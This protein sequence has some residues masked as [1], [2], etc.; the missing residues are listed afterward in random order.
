MCTVH[1]KLTQ[2]VVPPRDFAFGFNSR[3]VN[4]SLELERY[5]ISFNY[6]QK[7]LEITDP[8]DLSVQDFMTAVKE[9]REPLIGKAHITHN[10]LLLN[11]IHERCTTP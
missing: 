9:K 6:E 5:Q 11:Q 1:I 2:Q 8:L 3:I 4:R 7:T 10:T